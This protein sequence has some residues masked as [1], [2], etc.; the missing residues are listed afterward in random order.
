MNVNPKISQGK[1]Q[2]CYNYFRF[3]NIAHQYSCLKEQ[4][5]ILEAYSRIKRSKNELEKSI[6]KL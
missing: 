4:I 1:N 3:F 2:K 6:N 5:M